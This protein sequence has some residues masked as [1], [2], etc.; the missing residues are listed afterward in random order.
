MN[1][2]PAH[3]C[4]PNRGFR[5][6]FED[7]ARQDR[8]GMHQLVDD[9]ANAD[10]I[11]F[12]DLNELYWDVG[13]ATLASIPSSGSILKSRSFTRKTTSHGVLSQGFTSACL[14]LRF[15]GDG[16]A[17]V[18]TYFSRSMGTSRDERSSGVSP[19]LLFSFVG[20]GGNRV[21]EEILKLRYSRSVVRDTSRMDFFG[22]N[23]PQIEFQREEF[24][25]TMYRSKFVLCPRGA[26]TSSYRLFEAMQF[27][28]SRRSF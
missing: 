25:E 15:K 27:G 4:D 17:R 23:S 22:R 18:A 11:L 19:D 13:L 26:G 7:L 16:S 2:F 24:A 5:H 1:V 12:L 20:R 21:R 3:V 14:L 8:F 6:F 28:S 9:P 10:I